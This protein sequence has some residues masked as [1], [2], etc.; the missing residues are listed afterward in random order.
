MNSISASHIL[1]KTESEALDVLHKI[2][3]KEVSQFINEECSKCTKFDLCTEHVSKYVRRRTPEE[4]KQV[5]DRL[6]EC[7]NCPNLVDCIQLFQEELKITKFNMFRKMMLFKYRNCG[8][9]DEEK[10]RLDLDLLSDDVGMAGKMK[11]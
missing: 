10:S 9:N 4:I 6:R 1:V 5:Q 11:Q 7:A 8:A 2:V 3:S